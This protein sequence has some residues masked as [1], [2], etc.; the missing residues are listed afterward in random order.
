MKRVL[1]TQRVELVEAY[2]ER[3]ESRSILIPVAFCRFQF[4][5]VYSLPNNIYKNFIRPA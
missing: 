1:F 2:K 4:R 5:T 3:R